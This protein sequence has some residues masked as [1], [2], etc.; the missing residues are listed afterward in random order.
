MNRNKKRGEVNPLFYL[1]VIIKRANRAEKLYAK[2]KD[3]S[4]I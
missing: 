3:D 4:G 2:Y 1:K